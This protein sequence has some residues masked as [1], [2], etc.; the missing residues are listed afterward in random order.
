MKRII[1]FL[2][3]S[4]VF[5]LNSPE[6]IQKLSRSNYKLVPYFSKRYVKKYNLNKGDKE[7]LLQ[8]GYEGFMKACEKYD[9][10]RGTKIS[11]YSYFWIKKY[12]DDY[13]RDKMKNDLHVCLNDYKLNK[14]QNRETKT[15]SH[16]LHEY[17]LEPWEK[18]LL[19]KKYVKREK[20][21]EIAL[22]LNIS[23]NTLRTKYNRIY[24]KIRNQYY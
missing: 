15:L 18:N 22:E 20:F 24:D 21:K 23:R 3:L 16:I 10:T 9:D 7:E 11:T 8:Y 19:Y 17:K 2:H 13:I 4:L 1:L 5:C 6:K 14:I 12:M